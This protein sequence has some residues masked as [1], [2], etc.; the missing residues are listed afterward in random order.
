[1]AGLSTPLLAVHRYCTRL[2]GVP[3]LL[4]FITVSDGPCGKP[5]K[6]PSL[7]HVT[8]G[9][10]L[11]DAL[12][13]NDMLPPSTTISALLEIVIDGAT[14]KQK[15]KIK[16]LGADTCTANNKRQNQCET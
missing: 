6:L 8:T 12:Q 1:M 5:L 9:V 4:T 13:V 2:S 11:P 16:L 7:F 15:S 3:G 14:T 10:G